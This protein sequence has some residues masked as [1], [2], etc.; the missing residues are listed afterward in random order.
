MLRSH[1]V[2]VHLLLGGLDNKACLVLVASPITAVTVAFLGY[3]LGYLA[4]CISLA[5]FAVGDDG[6]SLSFQKVFRAH[7]CIVFGE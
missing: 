4:Y 2:N 1:E 3:Y 6:D 5:A 7:C